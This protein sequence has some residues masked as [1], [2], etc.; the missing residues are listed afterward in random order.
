MV[1]CLH[2]MLRQS[3]APT[4][5]PRAR[6]SCHAAGEASVSCACLRGGQEQP[7]RFPPDHHGAGDERHHLQHREAAS[8]PRSILITRHRISALWQFWSVLR[9]RL[10]HENLLPSDLKFGVARV[11]RLRRDRIEPHQMLHQIPTGRALPAQ[12][13]KMGDVIQFPQPGSPCL[14]I[15]HGLSSFPF[16]A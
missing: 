10:D 16:S 11:A 4:R 3:V 13:M 9:E 15:T 1:L 12:E 8:C 7:L 5:P 2:T 14:L 6:A